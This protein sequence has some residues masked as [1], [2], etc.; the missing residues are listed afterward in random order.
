MKEIKKTANLPI[1]GKN[2]GSKGGDEK[3]SKSEK[4]SGSIES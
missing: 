4:E 1:E 2:K 3:G